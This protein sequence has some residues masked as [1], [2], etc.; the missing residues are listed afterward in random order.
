MAKRTLQ[1]MNTLAVCHHAVRE[2]VGLQPATSAK[3][4]RRQR[5]LGEMVYSSPG[6]FLRGIFPS[7]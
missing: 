6:S 2:F 4:N 7:R 5:L 1:R 3:T